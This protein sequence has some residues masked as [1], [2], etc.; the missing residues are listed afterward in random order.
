MA[1]LN[2]LRS[3]TLYLK[4]KIMKTEHKKIF[5]G[6]SKNLT[7]ISWSINICLKYFM[8]PT[9]PRYEIFKIKENALNELPPKSSTI[10]GHLLRSH[11]FVYL[12]S[13][14]LD[15]CSKISSLQ[16]VDESLKMGCQFQPRILPPYHHTSLQSIVF[17]RNLQRI[18]DLKRHLKRVQ[19]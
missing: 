8:T 1:S 19:R 17:R 6:P 9:N 13:N 4:N 3:N 15:S 11:Y 16:T 14:L 5:C 7:N 2:I 18:V 12:C 10:R